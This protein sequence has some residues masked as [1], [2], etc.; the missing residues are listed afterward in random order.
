MKKFIFHSCALSLC[1]FLSFLGKGQNVAVTSYPVS[2]LSI[3][4]QGSTV[5]FFEIK[6]ENITSDDSIFI[7]SFIFGQGSHSSTTVDSII[8]CTADSNFSSVSR[9]INGNCNLVIN[10]WIKTS[11]NYSIYAKIP[12]YAIGQVYFYFQEINSQMYSYPSNN[13]KDY[14]NLY[15]PNTWAYDCKNPGTVNVELV[16]GNN[17]K[18]KDT[19]NYTQEIY[20]YIRV[21]NLPYSITAVKWFVNDSLVEEYN[22][23]N[24]SGPIVK[25]PYIGWIKMKVM[26]FLSDGSNGTDVINLYVKPNAI[27]VFLKSYYPD[28][29]CDNNISV[30]WE[31]RSD[32]NRMELT[33]NGNPI[34]INIDKLDNKYYY[35][36]ALSLQKGLNKLKMKVWGYGLDKGEDSIFFF[37]KSKPSIKVSVSSPQICKGSSVYLKGDTKGVS[38]YSWEGKPGGVSE[39][40]AF[41]AGTYIYHVQWSNGCSSDTVIFISEVPSQEKP[42]IGHNG[43]SLWSDVKADH[44]TWYFEGD[45]INS[46]DSQIITIKKSGY[47]FV[48][49]FN[50]YGC[51]AQSSMIWID[52][53]DPSGINDGTDKN[54][55]KIYPTPM[56]NSG[57]IESGIKGVVALI[58]L[59]GKRVKEF[60]VYPGKNSINVSD[61]SPGLYLVQLTND[62]NESL[63]TRSKII[64]QK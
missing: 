41:E 12:S 57:I 45:L 26:I 18:D 29:V 1:I 53:Q 50:K 16:V 6:V 5:K 47:Y 55:F 20:W 43:N 51:S 49:A 35:N 46:S 56:I 11:K 58:D 62:K 40:W 2:V 30:N 19:I 54:S 4:C 59:Q 24:T 61:L 17:Y 8:V 3:I 27:P 10:S 28:T 64:I 32:F 25:S 31:V 13:F 63:P 33:F 7:S 22:Y 23:W 42:A 44:F 60:N 52:Y 9:M 39:F 37:L 48:E 34:N 38:S 14:A 36:F 21:P 15:T